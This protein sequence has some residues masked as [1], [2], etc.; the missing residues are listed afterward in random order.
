MPAELA[1]GLL[2]AGWAGREHCASLERIGGARL[3]AVADPDAAAA[4]AVAERHGARVRAS[5]KAL[6]D[7]ESLDALIVCTPSGV[8]RDPVLA[9]LERGVPV[10]VEKPLARHPADA[11][12][13]ADAAE[14]T[15][16]VCA[17]AYQWRAVEALEPLAAALRD[18]PVALLLSQ[19]IGTSQS[20]PWWSDPALSGGIVFERASHHIDLQRAVAGEVGAVRALRGDVPLAGGAPGGGARDDLLVIE[21]RFASGALGTIALAWVA[22]AHPPAQSLRL[23]TAGTTYDLQLDPDFTL[24]DRR[25]ADPVAGSDEPPF[26]AQLRRFASA[27]RTRD[28]AGIACTARDAAGTVAVAAAIEAALAGATEVAVTPMAQRPPTE[29]GTVQ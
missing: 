20:R 9:A 14:R 26:V 12:A 25:S 3:V 29:N 15:G 21:L 17:V 19:G 2:G 22:G 6:L 1:F 16:T 28:P 4:A 24:Y 10:F 11:A 23:V 8:H 5:A 7:A 27:V 18:D 13:M